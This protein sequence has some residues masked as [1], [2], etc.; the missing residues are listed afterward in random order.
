MAITLKIAL[1]Q[2]ELEEVYLFRYDVYVTEM[3]RTPF[4]ADYERRI[5]RQPLD[6]V[7]INFAAYDGPQ[8]CGV[9]RNNFGA[10]GSFGSFREF[11]DLDETRCPPHRA[12][13]EEGR[14]AFSSMVPRERRPA[15]ANRNDERGVS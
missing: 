4:H 13:C 2:K 8:I 11:Y 7:G 6:D 10:D 3:K 14:H 12:C 9:V 15:S 5:L 1:T